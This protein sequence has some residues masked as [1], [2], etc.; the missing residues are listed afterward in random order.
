MRIGIDIRTL[1]DRRYSGVSNY[2]LELVNELL[3]QDNINQYKLYYNSG[4]DVSAR[5]PAFSLANVEIVATRFPN[6]IF[7]YGLQKVCHWPLL[8]RFLDVDIFL[9]PHIN[10]AALS[11][12]CKKIITIHDLSFLRYHHFFSLRKNFWHK[13]IGVKNLLASADAV[14]AV[15]ENT[16]RDLVEL[17]NVP[18]EKIKVIYSGIS[19]HFFSAS[20]NSVDIKNKYRLSEK[21]FLFLGNLEPRKNIEGIIRAYDQFVAKYQ[22]YNHYHLVLAGGKGWKYNSIFESLNSAVHKSKINF[23]GYIDEEDKKSLYSQASIFIYPSFYEGF[24]F[25]VL[26]ALACQIPVIASVNSSLPEVVNGRAVLVNPFNIND[27]SSAMFQ[28][29]NNQK[30]IK[31]VNCQIDDLLDVFNWPAA[32]KKYQALFSSLN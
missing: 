5:I 6:K 10:F 12:N 9:M 15:S 14:V 25:P 11:P 17:L 32:A 16:K 18:A 23:L 2:T 20:S 1:M 24:G 21:Y 22:E 7:N 4:Q 19:S 13:F 8:D 28:I 3:R 30:K 29:L 27:I 26:E 31:S